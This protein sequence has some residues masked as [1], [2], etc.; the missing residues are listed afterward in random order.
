MK[1]LSFSDFGPFSDW[2]L[3]GFRGGGSENHVLLTESPNGPR[4]RSDRFNTLY[5]WPRHFS[6]RTTASFFACASGYMCPQWAFMP[7]YSLGMTHLLR[8]V[9][10]SNLF[11]D[12]RNSSLDVVGL[13]WA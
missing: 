9:K 2:I 7:F 10:R 1:V 4:S 13:E 12:K 3:D 8:G 6:K 11:L 5:V